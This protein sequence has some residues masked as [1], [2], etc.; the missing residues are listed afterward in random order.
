L[1]SGRK[2]PLLLLHGGP[3]LPGDYLDPLGRIGDQRP[4]VTYDQLG[5]GRSDHPTDAALWTLD[6]FVDELVAVRE[7]LDLSRVHLFAHSWG[8]ML[9]A[10][11][12]IARKPK[13]IASVIFA[14]PC[15]S[16]ARFRRDTY[17]L[18]RTLS[19]ADQTAITRAEATGNYDAPAYKSA[20]NRFFAGYVVHKGKRNRYFERSMAGWNKAIH[21][22]TWGDSAFSVRGNLKD[23]DRTDDLASLDMPTLFLCGAY[24]E[25][26]PA[27]TRAYAARVRGSRVAVIPGAAHLMTIDAPIATNDAVRTF[28]NQVPD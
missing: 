16:A 17:A 20:V 23:F 10:E 8:T 28:L 18:A 3:G 19:R 12:L 7:A 15:L 11:Y 6:R 25:C 22:A 21:S 4:V 1:A 27:T 2:T 5:C 9:A 24:D 14:S 26:T 13:G